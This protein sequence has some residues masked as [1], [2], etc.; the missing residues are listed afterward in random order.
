MS[1]ED[2]TPQVSEENPEVETEPESEPAPET[3]AEP[4]DPVQPEPEP[5]TEP[6][7]EP[8]I[9][10]ENNPSSQ[11]VSSEKIELEVIMSE[12]GP[13][14][15]SCWIQVIVDGKLEFEQTILAGRAPM[16]FTAD[17]SIDFTY[18]NA[19][20]ITIIVNGEDQGIL[21]GN[22]EVGTKRFKIEEI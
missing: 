9:Q 21:G 14:E 6:V 18:G 12:G 13:G 19:A 17:E 2:N 1:S 15:E 7:T 10:P 16:R 3:G 8:E 22:G 11:E 20:A 4:E 5:V